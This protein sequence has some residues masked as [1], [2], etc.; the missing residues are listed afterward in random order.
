MPLSVIT[1]KRLARQGYVGIESEVLEKI[2]PWT[3]FS[4]AL[5]TAFMGAGTALASPL[6]LWIVCTTAVL[7]AIFPRHP[8]DL[9]YNHL[10]RRW[11]G[12]SPLPKNAAPRRFACGMAGGWLAGTATAFQ[13]G[14]AALGYALGGILTGLALLVSTTDICIPSMIYGALFGIPGACEGS[15]RSH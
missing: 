9:L 12:T 8:F 4:P 7:G 15:N 6:L 13:M 3:R 14:Q 2:A 10:V 5:C 1:Q 11:T